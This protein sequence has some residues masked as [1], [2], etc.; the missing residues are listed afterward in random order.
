MAD[1]IAESF[2]KTRKELM[3]RMLGLNLEADKLKG[4]DPEISKRLKE[5]YDKKYLRQII[6]VISQW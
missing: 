6:E 5:G 4:I 2:G 1:K 3:D